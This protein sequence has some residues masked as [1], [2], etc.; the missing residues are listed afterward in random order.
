MIFTKDIVITIQ[1]RLIETS[2]GEHGIKD[3]RLLDSAVSTIYQTFDGKELYPTIIEKASRLCFILNT[4]HAFVDGNKRIAMHMLALFL[5]FHDV[6]YK[7]SNGDVIRVGLGVAD[8]KMTYYE[9]LDW[10]KSVTK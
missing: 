7:P 9:L 6:E 2:G 4:S 10:V 3:L 1:K 8:N 5:R